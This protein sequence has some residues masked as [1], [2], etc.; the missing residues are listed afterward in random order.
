VKRRNPAPDASRWTEVVEMNRGK[1]WTLIWVNGNIPD[2]YRTGRVPILKAGAY[3][4]FREVTGKHV[5][6]WFCY[7]AVAVATSKGWKVGVPRNMPHLEC[8]Y[9]DDCHPPTAEELRE[10]GMEAYFVMQ[11]MVERMNELDA[12]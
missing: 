2:G 3:V 10:M 6:T 8:A 12:K 5:T 9:V 4:L 7:D 11:K 1:P